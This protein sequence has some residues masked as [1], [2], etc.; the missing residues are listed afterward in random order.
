MIE[1]TVG[2]EALEKSLAASALSAAGF[3]KESDLLTDTQLDAALAT[4]PAPRV[5]E[6]ERGRMIRQAELMTDLSA[7]L[8]ERIAAFDA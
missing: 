3:A 4:R 7:V 6:A 1:P 8:G 2:T 5:T